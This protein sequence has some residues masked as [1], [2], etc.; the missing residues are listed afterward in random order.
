VQ[1]V[2][3]AL[4][5][6]KTQMPN[7]AGLAQTFFG[8]PFE[9]LSHLEQRVIHDVVERRRTTR[10]I[11][12]T[13]DEEL[14]FGQR[15]ADRVAEFG[16]S[17]RFILIFL[18]TLVAWV[19]LNSYILARMGNQFDPY[20]YILLNLFLSMLAAFQAPVIMMSQNRQAA[21]D[22]ADMA[23]DYEVNLKSE[24][25]LMQ[26]H[27]KLDLLVQQKWQSL[28][29]AQAQQIEMLNRILQHLERQGRQ[30]GD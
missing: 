18:S 4:P 7:K 10:N 17:W 21:K 9:K 8:T 29:D 30:H 25:E 14:T 19:I 6:R 12:K 23:H 24:M 2:L 26:L 1:A 28:I 20:P 27:D 13:V 11:S 22:R 3:A 15:L 5:L 16:G